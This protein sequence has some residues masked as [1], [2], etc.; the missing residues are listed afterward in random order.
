LLGRGGLDFSGA[1]GAAQA[2]MLVHLPLEDTVTMDDIHIS[3]T[4]K[5]AD[6]HLGKIAADRDLDHAQIAL[7]VDNN[8]L[9]AAGAGAYAGIPADLTLTMDFR[10][11]ASNA[12]LQHVTAH[13]TATAAEVAAAGVPETVT[14]SFGLGSTALGVDYAARRDRTA[15]L[16][17]DADLLAAQLQTPLGWNKAP[18]I[19][20]SAGARLNFAGGKLVGIDHLHAEGPGL[21][22]ASH[23]RIE[24]EHTHA[25]V[26]DKLEI[27]HTRAHGEITFPTAP[28]EK[29]RVQFAGPMLDISTYLDQP[30]AERAKAV[31]AREDSA[32]VKPEQG[33]E[34]WAADLNF[35][36]VTLAKGKI[37]APF[38]LT[39]ATDGVHITQAAFTAGPPGAF[40]GRIAPGAGTRSI[41]VR[42]SDAG[43][44]LRAIGVADNLDGGHLQLD[45]VFQDDKAGDPL[46]GTA[47]LDNFNLRQ[48]P[49][50]GRLLQGMTLYGVLDL[51]RGPGLHFAK[52][53]A[54][55]R[56]QRRVL[57]LN[58]ARAFSPSLGV[59]AAGDIDL[60][61]RIANVKGTVVPAY[62]FNQL[63]GDLPI[64]GRIFSPEKG[65]GV[66]AARYSVTGPLSD[67]KVG[68]NPLSALTPGFLRE[69][70]GL[71]SPGEGK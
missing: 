49:A 26:L 58:S 23:A 43:V 67:P 12:V 44:F 9:S 20:A 56:W 4:A 60:R 41:A 37:L 38:K 34:P 64:V 69:V 25:L 2:R 57:T 22:I 16:L 36:A 59:T 61:R 39:A 33:S 54:P 21:L 45:G 30:A 10:D 11:G 17:L 8:G 40:E 32:P 47:T 51:L 14:K 27:G 63:L 70:F 35:A 46:T 50:I 24:A 68:V 62:F 42:S 65:G 5:L 48:A 66:F 7:K 19:A 15:T 1:S 52:L 71:L 31:P 13:G 3:A 28:T 29:L 6:V 53:V 55:F 18:G